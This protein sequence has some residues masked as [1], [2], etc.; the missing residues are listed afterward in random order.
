MLAT[1]E[2]ADRL[3]MEVVMEF[4]GHGI[5]SHFHT[6]PDIFHVGWLIHL[7]AITASVERF[8]YC[9]DAKLRSRHLCC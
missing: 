8:Q 9:L 1:S 3:G 7:N 5:G 4:C 6:A 2:I